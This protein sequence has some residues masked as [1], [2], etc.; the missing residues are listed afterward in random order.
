MSFLIF[1]NSIIW[2]VIVVVGI[3]GIVWMV[4]G[5]TASDEYDRLEALALAEPHPV[6]RQMKLDKL[7]EY[8]TAVPFSVH[9]QSLRKAIE[10]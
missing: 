6:A 5:D 4:S 10:S 9:Q 3:L 7:A 1:L 8:R 2:W